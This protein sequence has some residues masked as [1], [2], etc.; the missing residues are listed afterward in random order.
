[1]AEECADPTVKVPR[2]I[3]LCIPVGGFWGLLFI[4]PICFTLP[5]L[6]DI[7][8][9]PA[10][11]ALPY[12]F[13]RV[14]GSPG[15]GLALIFFVLAITIFCSISITTCASRCTWAFARKLRRVFHGSDLQR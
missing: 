9:A 4:L 8:E 2:A 3:S 1:M 13:A 7:L 5:P 10:G 12:I 15:G 11:Q 6:A 14:M